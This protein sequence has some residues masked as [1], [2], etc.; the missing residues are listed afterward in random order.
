M[1]AMKTELVTF[2]L[3]LSDSLFPLYQH[4]HV[5]TENEVTGGIVF[6]DIPLQ[7]IT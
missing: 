1:Y 3:F 5:S 2:L 6:V 4:S 7:T